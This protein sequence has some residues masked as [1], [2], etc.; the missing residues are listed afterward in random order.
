MGECKKGLTKIF[1]FKKIKMS[2]MMERIDR[3]V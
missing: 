3:D 1:E 2:T